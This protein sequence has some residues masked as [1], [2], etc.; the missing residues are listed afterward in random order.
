MKWVKTHWDISYLETIICPASKLHDACLLIKGK[1][2]DVH[3]TRRMVDGRW[4]PLH[5]PRMHQSGLRRKSH[6][7]ISISTVGGIKERKKWLRVK[8]PEVFLLIF[9]GHS[10]NIFILT[11]YIG[12]CLASKYG[13]REYEACP[14]HHTRLDPIEVCGHTNTEIL[15]AVMT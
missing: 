8:L 9:C 14:R 2:F 7:E 15:N 6:F 3:F 11:C 10:F 5:F 13:Q 4:L 12:Q 1:E